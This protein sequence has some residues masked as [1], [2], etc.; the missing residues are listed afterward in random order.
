MTLYT[1][2]FVTSVYVANESMSPSSTFT[3]MPVLSPVDVTTTL[4]KRHDVILVHLF[5]IYVKLLAALVTKPC[6]LRLVYGFV[7]LFSSM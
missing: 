1:T 6:P 2:P 3:F 4:R 7:K 5:V